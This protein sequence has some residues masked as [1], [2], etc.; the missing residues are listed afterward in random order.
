VLALQA[1]EMGVESTAYN[2]GNGQG[3]SVRE[4]ID[5][6]ARVT[7]RRV[8]FTFGPRRPGDPAALVGDAS[9]AIKELGWRPKF[10]NIDQI[11]ET[12][13]QWQNFNSVRVVK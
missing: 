9:R 10:Q 7:G 8:P 2:L 3:F 4:V 1:L 5:C 6:I 11:I 13:W 12:A